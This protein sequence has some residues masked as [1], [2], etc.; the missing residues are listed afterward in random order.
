MT[1]KRIILFILLALIIVAGYLTASKY[2]AQIY[3]FIESHESPALYPPG[4]TKYS[5]ELSEK[6]IDSFDSN[7]VLDPAAQA[8]PIVQK[9]RFMQLTSLFENDTIDLQYG[10]AE[11]LGDGRGITSGVAGFT[12]ADGDAY[13]VVRLYTKKSPNNLLAKYL[14]TMEK[15]AENGS[16]DT[17]KLKNYIKSWAASAND[18]VF[19]K[20]Q[21]EVIDVEYFNPAMK[22]ADKL[23][24]SSN[25]SKAFLY[26]TIIQHGDGDDPDS[27]GALIKTT[28]DNLGGTPKTGIDEKQWLSAFIQ[29]RKADLAH[30]YAADTRKEWAQSTGRCDVYNQ[31]VKDDNFDLNGP[32]TIKTSDY[33]AIIP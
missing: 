32:I 33:A 17:S 1:K 2:S 4:S 7:P 14:P 26:D 16:D 29:V 8:V 28:E 18:P 30:A 31:L 10:Y 19:K 24:L 20:A 23:G 6:F 21:D 9:T 27:I 11:D 22:Y 5:E 15:L 13:E 12:T 3:N 25:L